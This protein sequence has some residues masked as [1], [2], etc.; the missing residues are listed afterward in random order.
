[1]NEKLGTRGC[2]KP[3]GASSLMLATGGIYTYL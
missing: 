1:M 3:M 2:D